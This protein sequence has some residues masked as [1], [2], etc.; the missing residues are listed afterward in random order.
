MATELGDEIKV[1][2]A[3]RGCVDV[4]MEAVVAYRAAIRALAK[5]L[6]EEE[7]AG[8][9]ALSEAVPEVDRTSR[10]YVYANGVVKDTGPA[11]ASVLRDLGKE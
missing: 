8:W 11:W 2:E 4:H 6:W 1:P 3:L 7:Q 10:S 9:H 5:A